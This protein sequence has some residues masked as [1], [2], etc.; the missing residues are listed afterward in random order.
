MEVFLSIV[1]GEASGCELRFRCLKPLAWNFGKKGRH[2]TYGCVFFGKMCAKC[3]TK[4]ADTQLGL[5]GMNFAAKPLP[6]NSW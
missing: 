2:G 1:G 6:K 4:M 3:D 5:L